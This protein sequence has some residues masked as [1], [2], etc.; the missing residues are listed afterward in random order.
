MIKKAFKV[1]H[2]TTTLLIFLVLSTLIFYFIWTIAGKEYIFSKLPIGG[3][4]FNA[5]VYLKS[6]ADFMPFPP[7]GWIPYFNGGLPV[8]G[9]Y[10]AMAFYLIVLFIKNIDLATTMNYFSIISL[11]AFHIASLAL[12]YTISKNWLIAIG[13]VAIVAT[14]NATYYQL[15]V[16]GFITSASIQWLLPATLIFIYQFQQNRQKRFLTLA[17]IFSGMALLIQ[18]PSALLMVFT[19]SLIA[20]LFLQDRLP[21]SKKISHLVFFAS[22][23]SAIGAVGLYTVFLQTFFGSGTSRCTSQECWGIYPTHLERWLH[24]ASPLIAVCFFILAIIIKFFRRDLNL[25]FAFAAISALTFFAIYAA[26]AYFKLIN[27]LT[28]V[29]FPTRIFWAVNLLTLATAASFYRSIQKTFPQ[30][31]HFIAI[32]TLALITTTTLSNEFKVPQDR[33]NTI[34][35]DAALYSV[36]RYQTQSTSGVIP[37]WV[38]SSDNNWRIDTF[39]APLAQWIN[40]VVKKPLTRGYSNHPLGVHQDWLYYL[41]INTRGTED[42]G[43]ITKNQAL[44]SLDAFGIKFIENSIAPLPDS[45]INDKKIITKNENGSNSSWYEVSDDFTSP[46]VSPTNSPTLLFIG[47]NID[48]QYFVKVLA[49]DNINSK[50]LIPVKG[51]KDLGGLS[52]D[53]LDNFDAIFIYNSPLKN[54]SLLEK[55]IQGGKSVFIENNSINP[56]SFPDFF[57]AANA[58]KGKLDKSINYSLQ[59]DPALR[60][61]EGD[62]STFEFRGKPWNYVY[63]ENPKSWANLMLSINNKPVILG[64]KIGDGSVY[65]SGLNLPF[66]I[67]DN[68]NYEESKI[69]TTIIRKMIGEIPKAKFN[70]HISR[71]KPEEIKIQATNISGVY[72]KEN[73]DSGWKASIKDKKLEIYKAG[74]EFMFVPIPKELSENQTININY[75]G[76]TLTWSLFVISS[77]SIILA[78]FYLLAPQL[79]NSFIKKNSSFLKRIFGRGVTKLLEDE[80]A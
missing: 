7:Q 26:A 12:F 21:L 55:F 18:G 24:P 73:F 10:P 74:L 3:D 51:P 15:T 71:E 16:G 6:F 38:V 58:I 65:L 11:I 79:V 4:W 68:E 50:V 72:F 40:L 63:F 49:M 80:L 27:G 42:K 23:S 44:F 46:I 2:F 60:I 64:G 25:K 70:F 45:L 30:I 8:I 54:I 9:G 36:P 77:S 61:D 22:L 39:N 57:P 52:Y 41:Q 43:E 66:H 47:T 76:N 28:N 75:K 14:T 67:I 5:Y 56:E 69:T 13:L 62:F 35:Q 20:L 1:V 29:L 78:F 17:S 32:L 31:A 48:Y 33:T 59:I 37:D 19:P 34:P 53:K